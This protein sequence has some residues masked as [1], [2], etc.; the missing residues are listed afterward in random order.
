NCGMILDN[1]PEIINHCQNKNSFIFSNIDYEKKRYIEFKKIGDDS[2]LNLLG[3]SKYYINE[4]DTIP[5]S[6]AFYN[7]KEALLWPRFD[8][9]E[10][11][12]NAAIQNFI[13]TSIYNNKEPKIK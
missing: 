7:S 2:Y 9:L 1:N 11:V 12:I 3:R 4:A 6:D 5:L 13:K 10:C 8:D